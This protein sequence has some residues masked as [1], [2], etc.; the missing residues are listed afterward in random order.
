MEDG[1][2]NG[3]DH[4]V[5]GDGIPNSEDPDIDGDGI[6][7]QSSDSGNKS[8]TVDSTVLATTLNIDCKDPDIDGDGIPN[9]SKRSEKTSGAD[10]QDLD[11]DGDGIPNGSDYVDIDG[12][13]IPNDQDGDMDCDGVPNAIDMDIDCDG[14]PNGNS[15][16]GAID[17]D[18]NCNGKANGAEDDSD[19]DGIPDTEDGSPYGT[20]SQWGYKKEIRD[21][22]L[23]AHLHRYYRYQLINTV[24][25]HA[26]PDNQELDEMN[27][28]TPERP[29]DDPRYTTF[30]GLGGDLVKFIYPDMYR[31]NVFAGGKLL[32]KEAIEA[33]IKQYLTEKIQ[34]YNQYLDVQLSKSLAYY[35]LHDNEYKFLADVDPAASPNRSY[36]MFPD[37]YL[38]DLIGDRNIKRVA[39]SLY[40]LNVAWKEDRPSPWTVGTYIDEARTNFDLN[41]KIEF[42]M[43]EYL[44]YDDPDDEFKFDHIAYPT[45]I[46]KT[47]AYEAGMISSDGYDIIGDQILFDGNDALVPDKP[48]PT[49]TNIWNTTHR[50][51]EQ[52]STF[53]AEQ[54]ALC[55]I[56]PSGEVPLLK[57]PKAVTCRWQKTLENP[58]DFRFEASVDRTVLEDFKDGWRYDEWRGKTKKRIKSSREGGYVSTEGQVWTFT[59]SWVIPQVFAADASTQITLW[60][61]KYDWWNHSGE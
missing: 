50:A 49:D 22:G 34:M 41:E 54:D 38:I 44:Q 40:H 32:E 60:G 55:N 9:K 7:N 46:E 31:V 12:D 39:E 5:D 11:I 21:I 3:G 15:E 8:L 29:I 24:T 36:A 28:I 37:T 26:G 6:P 47:Y 1:V 57:W 16:L 52:A 45:H 58:V 14:I 53:A 13:G 4:D 42:V 30:H 18:C 35:E 2:E 27:A 48:T 20:F 10:C 59:N 17:K 51:Y 25:K 19:S 56:P 33:N 43:D 61:S 23:C